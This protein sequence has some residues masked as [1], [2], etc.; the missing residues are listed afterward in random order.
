MM[1]MA[2]NTSL[3]ANGSVFAQ[4]SGVADVVM[5]VRDSA[6][7]VPSKPR[8]LNVLLTANAFGVTM[9][10]AQIMPRF[11]AQYGSYEI[12]PIANAFA[13]SGAQTPNHAFDDDPFPLEVGE[14]LPVQAAQAAAGNEQEYI[15]LLFADAK[16]TRVKG[17]FM[18]IRLTGTT[19][20]VPKTWSACPLVF[21]LG[22]PKGNY[23]CVGARVEGASPLYFRFIQ[24]DDISRPGGIAHQSALALDHP[25]QRHGARGVWFTFDYLTPPTLEVFATA[26][27][28]AQTVLLDIA[29]I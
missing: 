27:D 23:A 19:T 9:V 7:I 10:R 3:I 22:L 28:T 21:D 15:G 11:L 18:T 12:K 16:P 2:A 24:S 14:E 20:L 5:Q 6:L 17:S 26:A 29:K 25:N 13:G 4:L 8:P 1:H